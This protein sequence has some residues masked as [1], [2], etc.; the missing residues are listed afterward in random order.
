MLSKLHRH[1]RPALASAV[2]AGLA[3]C[4][5]R[6]ALAAESPALAGAADPRVAAAPAD[7]T[8]SAA[9]AAGT[10]VDGLGPT[11][12]QAIETPQPMYP[13][14]ARAAGHQGTVVIG[15][16]VSERGELLQAKV[17]RSSRSPALDQAALD[18]V[19]RWRFKPA[20]DPSG[21]PIEAAA[22]VPFTFRKDSVASLPR[23]TCAELNLDMRHWRALEPESP[24]QQAPVY[25]LAQ[26]LAL[27]GLQTASA[28]QQ[29]LAHF[30]QAFEQAVQRCAERP[31]A[32]V[33]DEIR[34]RLRALGKMPPAG[35][36]SSA[37]SAE[38]GPGT[39]SAPQP[40][41][42]AATAAGASADGMR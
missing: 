20:T 34:L 5:E 40:R 22:N 27:D 18:A 29:A 38:P 2:L 12:L 9:S 3:V 28:L 10:A 6:A 7:S 39:Q 4:P 42:P 15:V 14:A 17:Q 13:P 26:Q 30:P 21:Q 1:V 19:H 37:P 31:A 8:L 32:R 36:A 35:P 24:L 23:K 16:L 41:T 33:M 25:A 11:R